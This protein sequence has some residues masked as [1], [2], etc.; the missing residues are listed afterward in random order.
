MAEVCEMEQDDLVGEVLQALSEDVKKIQEEVKRL[1]KQSPKDYSD[2]LTA[3]TKAVEGLQAKSQLPPPVVVPDQSGILTRLDRLENTLRQRPEYRMSQYV[4][5]GTYGFGLMVV[6]LVAM[7]WLALDWRSER[8][9]Y[10]QAY[11]QDNWRIRYI[12]QTDPNF[13]G[14]V[15]NLFQKDL[16]GVQQWTLEQEQADQKRELAREAAEQAKT[17]SQ[18]ANELEGKPV[19]KGKKK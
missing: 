12:R 13:Y 5:Y 6:L 2:T 11:A 1:P 17:L 8:E 9:Q 19:I 4:R 10:S 3:L 15:E 14:H 18:Q 16:A 7:T